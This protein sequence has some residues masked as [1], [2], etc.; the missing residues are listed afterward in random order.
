MMQKSTNL[1]EIEKKLKL[2]RGESE[3]EQEKYLFDC[4]LC[5]LSTINEN[6]S[7]NDN[8]LKYLV[9]TEDLANLIASQKND[10]KIPLNEI[11]DWVTIIIEIWGI[12][13]LL[14]K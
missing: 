12:Y 6:G 14:H 4:M 1:L 3:N 9:S 7:F 13:L 5:I 8:N 2:L 10:A 11:K